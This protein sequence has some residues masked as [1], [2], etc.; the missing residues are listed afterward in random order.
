MMLMGVAY[1]HS[2]SC[3]GFAFLLVTKREREEGVVIALS[4]GQQ[5]GS[6][7]GRNHE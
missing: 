2:G 4:S 7:Y 3:R 1:C 5:R 6:S